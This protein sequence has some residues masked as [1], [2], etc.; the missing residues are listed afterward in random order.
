L[1]KQAAQVLGGYDICPPCAEDFLRERDAVRVRVRDQKERDRLARTVARE[2][3]ATI[4]ARKNRNRA[5]PF[6]AFSRRVLHAL[7]GIPELRRHLSRKVVIWVVSVAV[8]LAVGGY[9]SY[10]IFALHAARTARTFCDYTRKRIEEHQANQP[11]VAS[12][13]NAAPLYRKAIAL[14]PD[15]WSVPSPCSAEV[16]PEEV[17]AFVRKNVRYLDTLV[18]ATG[19]THC[20]FGFDIAGGV[21]ALPR[22]IFS[23]QHAAPA[24]AC[25]A[26]HEARSGDADKALSYLKALLNLGRH[27]SQGGVCLNQLLTPEKY[28]LNSLRI[29]LN[30]CDPSAAALEKLLKHLDEYLDRRGSL[31]E[32]FLATRTMFLATVRLVLTHTNAGETAIGQYLFAKDGRL[33]D[34]YFIDAARIASKPFSEIADAELTSLD[35]TRQQFNELPDWRIFSMMAMQTS[36]SMTVERETGSLARLQLARAAIACRLYRIEHG[37]YPGQLP[38]TNSAAEGSGSQVFTDPFS[39]ESLGY[40]K[41]ETGCLISSVGRDR[42]ES[43]G[44]MQLDEYGNAIDDDVEFELKR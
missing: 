5:A 13:H 19:K 41:T 4:A 20:D 37:T 32:A 7:R 9:L 22:E 1:V 24:L 11:V 25:G 42:R 40:R 35:M 23:L 18:A 34:S 39:G 17:T 16:K 38:A 6:L 2:R 29:V 36:V 15:E 12:E 21:P 27:R 44:K 33:I 8:A 43:S 3:A 30:E 31:P 10:G 26:V 14:M 28:F